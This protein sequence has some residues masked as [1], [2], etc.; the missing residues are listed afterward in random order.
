MQIKRAFQ[1]AITITLIP[2]FLLPPVAAA[3][4][5][6]DEMVLRKSRQTTNTFYSGESTSSPYVWNPMTM[7]YY[8]VTTGAELWKFTN[9]GP[10]NYGPALGP[11]SVVSQT[12]NGYDWSGDGKYI[13][14]SFLQNR[15]NPPAG[16][17]TNAYGN[18]DGKNPY[19]VT[20]S[21]FSRLRPMSGA[22]A[23]SSNHSDLAWDQSSPSTFW[24]F[25]NTDLGN[26]GVARDKLYRCI[27]GDSSITCTEKLH[28]NTGTALTLQNSLISPDGKK[29]LVRP[30]NLP[31]TTLYAVSLGDTATIDNGGHGFALNQ[32][33]DTTYWGDTIATW[34]KWHSGT[35]WLVKPEQPT[36][37]YYFYELPDGDIGSATIWMCKLTGT[38][39]DGGCNHIVDHTAPYN[40]G[41]LIPMMAT[42]AGATHNPWNNTYWGHPF[43]DRWGHYIAYGNY[44]AYTAEIEDT[45]THKVYSTNYG[46]GSVI[47][48]G[49]WTWTDWVV[50]QK[51][52]ATGND[53]TNVNMWMGHYA[54]TSPPFVV[55]Y[56][57]AY[58]N[59]NGIWSGYSYGGGGAESPDG[60]KI[61]WSSSFL[62]YDTYVAGNTAPSHDR[63]GDLYTAVVYY[64]YPPEI[65]S[66]SAAGGTVTVRFDWG[67]NSGT[68]RGYTQR[69]WPSEKTGSLLPPRET[70]KF[71]LWRSANKSSWT[72]IKTVDANIW[73]KYNFVNG[74]YKGGQTSYWDITDTPGNGT[75]YYGVTAIENSG[76]ES[77]KLSNIYSITVTG[78]SGTGAQ[79]I[80]YPSSPGRSSNFY[81]SAPFPPQRLAVTYKGSPAT[82]N[83]QYTIEWTEP[84]TTTLV[85][86][87]NIYAL[88]GVNPTA[89]QQRRVASISRNSCSG[90]SCSWV[91][92]LG[93]TGGT[94]KYGVT[95]VDT[96][97]NE[98]PIKVL[99]VTS[100]R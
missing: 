99:G 86:H 41:E 32:P 83:G 53:W 51:S 90:G 94:T 39:A 55:Y 54:K 10:T 34:Y 84:A 48:A 45:Y 58:Y 47:A 40:F 95:S 25:G 38:S 50:F 100:N 46:M 12:I 73:T 88:D 37:D 74:G 82:A 77:H 63:D 79:G 91:D 87:Y 31:W 66:T 8:D 23:R 93:N 72:P 92:W 59:N 42:V 20:N 28:F 64:P 80:A 27:L 68:W 71:R 97:G 6:L 52:A 70:S 75:F 36:S 17:Y 60:S 14:F 22:A 24:Q 62:K 18:V 19:M 78:G 61:T 69:K 56:P 76:L 26:T 1:F 7:M 11:V 43:Q 9:F 89:I 85:R 33:H 44:N 21:D 35:A 81:T 30:D 3:V 4:E 15:S 13:V 29:G 49:L 2:L 16:I 65:Y 98:S 5:N 57:H 96:L 67:T